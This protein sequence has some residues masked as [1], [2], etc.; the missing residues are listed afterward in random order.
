MIISKLC[1]ISGLVLLSLLSC[2]TLHQAQ[3]PSERSTIR[4]VMS[5]QENAWNR[6]DLEGFMQGYWKS[7]KLKFIG[8]NGIRYGWD[9]TLKAYKKGYPDRATMG[10]L[11]FEIESLEPLGKNSYYMV[12]QYK[13]LRSHDQPSGYFTLVWKKI[14]GHWKIISDMTC[15]K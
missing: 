11:H 14:D 9:N 10:K 1:L 4:Q 8:R 5:A 2:S 7:D 13:L 15:G 6:G 12:G 3:A